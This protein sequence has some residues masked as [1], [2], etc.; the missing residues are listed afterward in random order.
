MGAI[1]LFLKKCD[2]FLF[3]SNVLEMVLNGGGLLVK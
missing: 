3:V 2:L 1:E